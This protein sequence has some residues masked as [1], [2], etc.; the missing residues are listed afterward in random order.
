M[1][2]R[3]KPTQQS[4]LSVLEH[5]KSFFDKGKT[6]SALLTVLSKAF[7]FLDHELLIA[8]LN[9]YEFML[10]GLKQIQNHLSNRKRRTKI[11]SSWSEWLE[12]IFGVPQGSIPTIFLAELFFIVIDIEIAIYACRQHTVC[13]R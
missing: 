8:I 4:L 12:I 7:D 11:N 6:F 5:W 1:V 13:K 10:P 9:A 3:L 2:K